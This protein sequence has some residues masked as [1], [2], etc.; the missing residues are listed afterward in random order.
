MKSDDNFL[1]IKKKIVLLLTLIM[2]GQD[3]QL[4]S[5][6][7]FRVYQHLKNLFFSTEK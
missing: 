6:Q 2:A 7:A 4:Q 5:A 1:P 3:M